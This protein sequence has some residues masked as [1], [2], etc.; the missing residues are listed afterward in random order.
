VAVSCATVAAA[1]ATLCTQPVAW[2]QQ[3]K[4]EQLSSAKIEGG[5]ASTLQSGRVIAITR[6]VNLDNTNWERKVL[7][8]VA[9]QQSVLRNCN[10]RNANLF[11]ASFFDADLS[12]SDFSGADMRQVNLEMADLSKADLTGADLTQAYMA[13][14]V[15]KNLEK[16]DDTDW[17]DVDMR[18][19][20]RT[21]LCTVAKGTNP[22]TGVDTRDSLACPD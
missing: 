20:Q 9:F 16:I 10:F 3:S 8:G 7:K 11:S 18:K 19:D 12:G 1:L 22:S 4:A 15:I 21:Y 14:A 13:G 5:G 2:A 6:G 17:T